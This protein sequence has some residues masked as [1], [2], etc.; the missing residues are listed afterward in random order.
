MS[1]VNNNRAPN[2][3][4]GQMTTPNAASSAD[5]RA[6]NSSPIEPTAQTS[7]IS[8]VPSKSLLCN[9]SASSISQ[10]PARSPAAE[11]R[12]AF[13]RYQEYRRNEASVAAGTQ[14]RGSRDAQQGSTR[15]T[16]ATRPK[17]KAAG[18]GMHHA[19]GKKQ[20][21]LEVSFLEIF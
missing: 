9:S 15:G 14:A 16:Q 7:H 12:G 1:I 19:K 10:E 5:L 21:T 6:Q 8:S 13:Q 4:A 11:L 17:R 20:E 3:G 18:N 2:K